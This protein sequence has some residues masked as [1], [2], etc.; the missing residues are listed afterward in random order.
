MLRQPSRRKLLFWSIVSFAL[1]ALG[2]HMGINPAGL[3][4]KESL[5]TAEGFVTWIDAGD[6]S[7]AFSLHG[8]DDTFSYVAK[9]G[10]LRQVHTGLL[11]GR[12][13]NVSLLFDPANPRGPLWTTEKAFPVYELRVGA[14]AIRAY[15]SVDAA[16]R[17][18]NRI[19]FWFGLVCGAIGVF[20]AIHAKRLTP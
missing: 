8:S 5:K 18:D 9:G 7:I 11:S 12:Q 1:C 20:L 2:L 14:E 4:P 15:E 3:P 17:A 19:G 16:W 6:R 10:G 13:A